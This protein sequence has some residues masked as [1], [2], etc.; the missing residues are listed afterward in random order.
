MKNKQN[1]NVL[2]FSV[3][4]DRLDPLVEALTNLIEREF[5]P[6]LASIDGL[7][8]F[9]IIATRTSRN[10]FE[11]IRYLAA[12]VPDDPRRK[13]EFA[14]VVSPLARTLAD[15]IFT[16]VFMK[17]DLPNRVARYHQGGWREAKEDHERHR[18][19]YGDLQEWQDALQQDDSTLDAAREWWGVPNEAAN[20]PKVLPY[21]PNPGQMLREKDLSDENKRF[22]TF[23]NDFV[24]RGLSADAH[25]SAFGIIRQHMFLLETDKE[26]R[27]QFLSRAKSAGTFTA[28]TLMVAICTEINDIC[29]YEK[30]D[31]PLSYLWGVLVEYWLPA[32]D[33]FERRYKGLLGKNRESRFVNG[34]I[35]TT[36]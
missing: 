35:Q 4:Q 17:E 34:Q 36:K 27:Q 12:D 7:Q 6:A 23:L 14:L 24:Y 18:S 28:T 9:L 19:E 21:W 10:T 22:L 31:D 15:L 32:K 26:K 29:R 3:I 20:R 16:L 30:K 13:L 5:P 1:S 25:V 8:P 33:L 2:P 11:A